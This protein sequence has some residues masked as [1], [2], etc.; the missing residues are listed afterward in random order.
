MPDDVTVELCRRCRSE[1]VG[2]NG[3]SGIVRGSLDGW[4][5]GGVLI[6]RGGEGGGGAGG[7]GYGCLSV[8]SVIG[9][10]FCFC[11]CCWFF[12]AGEE[13][14]GVWFYTG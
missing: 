2:L 12:F 4:L 1:D 7:G 10:V 6:V 3:D 13:G 9:H 14:G 8:I 11:F 5:S